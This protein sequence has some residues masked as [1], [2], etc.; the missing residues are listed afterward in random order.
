M[1]VGRNRKRNRAEL[2]IEFK[3]PTETPKRARSL[4][5]SLDKIPGGFFLLYSDDAELL[6]LGVGSELQTSQR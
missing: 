5:R 3:T 6:F 4:A 2:A 1:V